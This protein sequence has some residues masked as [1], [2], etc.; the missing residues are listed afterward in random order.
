MLQYYNN[1][2]DN[3]SHQDDH[4]LRKHLVETKAVRTTFTACAPTS[5]Q[6]R[7][8]IF[9]ARTETERTQCCSSFQQQNPH[10][11]HR[12]CPLRNDERHVSGMSWT[13]ACETLTKM[14]CECMWRRLRVCCHQQRKIDLNRHTWKKVDAFSF[15]VSLGA[16]LSS[17]FVA[18]SKATFNK[19]SLNRCHC[20]IIWA[21]WILSFNILADPEPSWNI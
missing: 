18:S 10:D 16:K 21:W 6:S 20:S 5:L 13:C 17:V 4:C 19:Y 14:A 3:P 15:Y 1:I 8:A 11:K 12:N 9:H 2:E 7:P